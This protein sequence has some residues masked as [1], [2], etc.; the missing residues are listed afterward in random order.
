MSAGQKAIAEFIPKHAAKGETDLR[1]KKPCHLSDTSFNF[2]SKMEKDFRNGLNLA[3]C[4]GEKHKPWVISHQ[5]VFS[6][7]FVWRIE[8]FRK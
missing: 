1:Q 7:M 2:S 6:Y 5:Q 4:L 3:G 8:C